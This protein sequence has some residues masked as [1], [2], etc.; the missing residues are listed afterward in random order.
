MPTNEGLAAFSEG[1][2]ELRALFETMQ[3]LHQRLTS[4][5]SDLVIRVEFGSGQPPFESV[6]ARAPIREQL[7]ARDDASDD[8]FARM[9]FD[10]CFLNQGTW[11]CTHAEPPGDDPVLE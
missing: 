3:Q 8:Q 10:K 9:G 11:C 5:G 7:L 2:P 1:D 6:G 4:L